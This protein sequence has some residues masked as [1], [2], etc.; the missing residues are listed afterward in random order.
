MH[1]PLKYIFV[2]DP[3]QYTRVESEIMNNVDNFPATNVSVVRQGFGFNLLKYFNYH[4]SIHNQIESGIN[5]Q[6]LSID[7]LTDHEE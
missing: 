6:R 7:I 2:Q 3:E 5:N 1:N 4:S